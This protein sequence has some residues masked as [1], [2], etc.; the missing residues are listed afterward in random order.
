MTEPMQNGPRQGCGIRKSAWPGGLAVMCLLSGVPAG[1][2]DQPV[3]ATIDGQPVTLQEVETAAARELKRAEMEFAR[4]RHEV[5]EQALEQ[6]LAQKLLE[7]E[8]AARGISQEAL[9]QSLQPAAVTE[10][11]IDAF[12]AENQARLSGTREQFGDRIRQYLQEQRMH[13]A[14]TQLLQQMKEGHKVQTLLEP[15][16]VDVAP[17]G[18]AMG[19]EDAPVTIVEFSDF[20]C[21]Y[22]V[23]IYPALQDLVRRYQGK[24]RLVYRHFPLGIHANARKAAEASLCAQ[25]QGKFWEMHNAMFDNPRSLTP[26]G[27]KS[28]AAGI[29]LS[30]DAFNACLDSGRFAAQ[31]DRDLADGEI[32]G[33]NGTPATFVNGRMLS[34]AVPVEQLAAII[35]EELA[36]AD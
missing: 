31:V 3:L 12:Y 4:Q 17:L 25:E 22:C 33:V 5:L 35:D 26:P 21:P 15:Y 1:A 14:Y 7:R 6:L 13:A 36:R 2:V 10:Q 29:G 34:G 32:L 24:V 18:A 9:L 28:L 23:R 20:E 11:D 8:A 16:R 19:P 30:S 27:L